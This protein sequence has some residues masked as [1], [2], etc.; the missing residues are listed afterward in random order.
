MNVGA[1]CICVAA[2]SDVA[3]GRCSSSPSG[4]AVGPRN[5]CAFQWKIE[6]REAAM[7]LL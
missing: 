5:S 6:E 4:G 1:E 3:D 2:V 7:K